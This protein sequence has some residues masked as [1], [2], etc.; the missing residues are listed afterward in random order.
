MRF[1][2][3]LN[4]VEIAQVRSISPEEAKENKLFENI[5]AMKLPRVT[6]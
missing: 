6:K 5:A 2:D 1:R 3:Y 4:L